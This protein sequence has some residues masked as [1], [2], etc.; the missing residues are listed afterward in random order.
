MRNLT[1]LVL[2]AYA[3]LLAGCNTMQGLGKDLSTLGNKIEKK[4]ELK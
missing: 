1:M 4:A 3:M 2:L